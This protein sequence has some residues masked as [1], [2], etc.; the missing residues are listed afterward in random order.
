MP[1]INTM[2]E[3]PLH[4]IDEKNMSD[5]SMSSAI[6]FFWSISI[7][8]LFFCFF[9][10]P[11]NLFSLSPVLHLGKSSLLLLELFLLTLSFVCSEDCSVPHHS[12]DKEQTH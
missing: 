10:E 8:G 12:Q 1:S 2:K 9:L 3:L 7:S 6:I 5:P 4:W 11:A